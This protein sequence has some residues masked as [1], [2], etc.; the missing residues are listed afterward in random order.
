[1]HQH[2]KDTRG[3]TV[4]PSNDPVLALDQQRRTLA[5]DI[6]L[7]VVRQHRRQKVSLGNLADAANVTALPID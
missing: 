7:L 6:A 5:E 1:M 2:E 3:S 4:S